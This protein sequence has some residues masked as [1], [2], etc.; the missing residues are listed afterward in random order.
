[1]PSGTIPFLR[2][3]S[4]PAASV[5]QGSSGASSFDVNF[6]PKPFDQFVVCAVSGCVS[7]SGGVAVG[8]VSRVGVGLS[9]GG[10]LTSLIH[11]LYVNHPDIITS[12]NIDFH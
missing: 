2:W 8:P 1:M 4:R 12:R 9:L 5:R 7:G 11:D 10:L 6:M 3:K